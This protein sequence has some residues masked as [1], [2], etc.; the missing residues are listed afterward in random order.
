MRT[1][2]K[3]SGAKAIASRSDRFWGARA[4]LTLTYT[5]I[6]AVILCISSSIIYT[7]FSKRLTERFERFPPRPAIV[8]PETILPPRAEDVLHD[9]INALVLVNGLLLVLASVMSYWLAGITLEPIQA[10]YER[11]RRFLSDASHEL[12][13][14]LAILQADLE[15][16]LSTLGLSKTAQEQAESHLEEVARMATIVKDLLLLS[17]LDETTLPTEASREV[18]LVTFLQDVNERFQNFA[19]QHQ[20]TLSFAPSLST[21]PIITKSELLTQAVSNLVKNAIVYNKPAGTVEIR[22]AG[23][24][25]SAQIQIQDTGI[26]MSPEDVDKVSERFYRVDKSRSRQT[27]GSGLGLSITRSII[28]QLQGSIEMKSE[29]GQGTTVTVTLPVSSSS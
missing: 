26:G 22:L 1:A 21:L 6:L 23:D 7:A 9:L 19:Q 3:P 16:N 15:N 18:D 20:V 10:A 25:S 29:F 12:R 28:D 14:P 13:T 11:Q 17:R 27:G 24:R 8:S 2:S 4:Q 5:A